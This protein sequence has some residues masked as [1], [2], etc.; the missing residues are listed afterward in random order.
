MTPHRTCTC[1][2]TGGGGRE[3]TEI[4]TANNVTTRESEKKVYTFVNSTYIIYWQ[5]I[6]GQ[7]PLPPRS[8]RSCLRK[9]G[10]GGGGG[11]GEE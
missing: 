4:T 1:S 6:G 7:L 8:C 5:H 3:L 10:G 2:E 11:G 9:L